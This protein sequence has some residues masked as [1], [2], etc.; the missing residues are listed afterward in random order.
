MV[1]MVDLKAGKPVVS[2][3]SGSPPGRSSG[4]LER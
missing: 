1:D 3:N 2:T 4:G